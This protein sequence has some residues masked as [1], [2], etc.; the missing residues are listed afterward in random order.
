MALD[1]LPTATAR[2]HLA[3]FRFQ[4][5]EWKR[6][7]RLGHRS[8]AHQMQWMVKELRQAN[9]RARRRSK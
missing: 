4:R 3:E 1:I 9:P 6:T 2:A 8:N 7:G 5:A